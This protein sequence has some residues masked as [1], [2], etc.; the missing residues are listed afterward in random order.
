MIFLAFSYDYFEKDKLF[1]FFEI[2][3]GFY[4]EEKFLTSQIKFE[5]NKENIKEF[6][7]G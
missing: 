1:F 2:Y 4:R 3:E 6:N 5:V 7:L